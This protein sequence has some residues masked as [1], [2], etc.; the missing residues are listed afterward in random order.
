MNGKVRDRVVVAKDAAEAD[1]LAVAKALPGVAKYL[2]GM[3]LVKKV[4]VPG[5]VVSLVVR[6]VGYRAVGRP[7]MVG[8]RWQRS[9]GRR[10][11]CVILLGCV[12][13]LGAVPCA[14][15]GGQTGTE[16][17]AATSAAP[18]STSGTTATT[19]MPAVPSPSANSPA[20]VA[21]SDAAMVYAE[22]LGGVSHRGQT[23]YFVIGA[24]VGS[25]EEAQT[26]LDEAAALFGDMQ[27]YFIVQ[28]SSNFDGLEPGHWV[29]I[30]AYRDEP[31]EEALAFARRGFPD[32]YVKEAT[33]LT[34]D[35]IP[36]YEELMGL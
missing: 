3:T 10:W 21:I 13:S 34:E 20:T 22:D 5:H 2:E 17:T 31:S 15:G 9:V 16:N 32:A 26:L 33:V 36:V 29:I 4:V 23:L 12:T 11:A 35:P 14:C 19:K 27:S 18:Q 8:R 25:E 1:I 6:W 28:N 7:V 24:S 30:E